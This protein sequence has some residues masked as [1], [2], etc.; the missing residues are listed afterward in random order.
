MGAA[1]AKQ[2][3]GG[4][5]ARGADSRSIRAAWE[6]AVRRRDSSGSGGGGAPAARRGRVVGIWL[7]HWAWRRERW[8]R[9]TE[10]EAG[11]ASTYTSTTSWRTARLTSYGS[12]CDLAIRTDRGQSLNRFC[13]LFF[14]NFSI[15]GISL[16]SL[17]SLSLL[18]ILLEVVMV[19]KPWYVKKPEVIWYV[20]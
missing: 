14:Q 9:G 18:I 12:A 10:W 16:I 17:F 19:I 4:S 13:V 1:T 3:Y 20:K 2:G 5:G 7:R 8:L 15:F 11:R 6:L